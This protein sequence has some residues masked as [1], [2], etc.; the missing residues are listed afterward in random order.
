M[1]TIEILF[2]LYF[3]FIGTY[4]SLILT[5]ALS[6]NGKILDKMD[7]RLKGWIMGLNL[8]D[9]KCP[10]FLTLGFDI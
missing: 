3:A 1:S 7:E 9:S 8:K 2:D 4:V 10:N 6:Q 5:K